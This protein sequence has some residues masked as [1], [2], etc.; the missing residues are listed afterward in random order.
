MRRHPGSAYVLAA[1][2]ALSLAACKPAAPPDAA[3]PAATPAAASAD[4]PSQFAGKVW[5]VK[6]SATVEKG[7]TYAFLADGHLVIDGP[8]GT[9][10]QAQWKFDGGQLTIIEEGQVYPTDILK[11]DAGEFRIRSHNPGE[12][13]EVLLVPAADQTLPTAQANTSI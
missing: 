4:A 7:T 1:L 11:L 8:G 2:F 6:E 10:L 5:E 9:P 12:P 13:V 3:A